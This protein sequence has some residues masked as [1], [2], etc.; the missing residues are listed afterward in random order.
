MIS[1]SQSFSD[2]DEWAALAVVRIV[3]ASVV[4][5]SHADIMFA[6]PAWI[7]WLGD[8]GATTAVFGFFVVSGYCIAHSIDRRPQGFYRRRLERIYPVFLASFL[9]ALIP[10]AIWGWNLRV[11]IPLGPDAWEYLPDGGL[12][13]AT[14]TLFFLNGFL[15]QTL[16]SIGTAWSLSLE[17]FFYALAPFLMRLPSSILIF[18][19]L[20][21]IA[22]RLHPALYFGEGF[23]C[24]VKHIGYLTHGAGIPVT[25]WAW[26]LG[27]VY[28]RHRHNAWAKL[29]LLLLGLVP[30]A[31]T[32]GAF[33]ALTYALVASV[34]IAPPKLP[35]KLVPCATWLGDLSYPLYLVQ[36]PV[37]VMLAA[38]DRRPSCWY[39]LAFTILGS[40]LV[41]HLVD[42]PAQRFFRRQRS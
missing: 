9:I 36:A 21:S 22:W 16:G 29:V 34:L 39:F 17:V 25:A 40:V 14:G 30:V 7:R 11:R 4:L 3:L 32:G 5:A 19:I 10:Y 42:Y 1:T 12:W 24:A 31:C 8:F 20:G 23:P 37:L 28:Y 13:D 2:G 41:L 33:H 6:A 26:L 38:N 18:F 15:S 35:E 27:F